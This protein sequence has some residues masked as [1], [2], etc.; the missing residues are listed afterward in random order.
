VRHVRVARDVGCWGHTACA[1]AFKSLTI[2]KNISH[3]LRPL[4]F[5]QRRTRVFVQSLVA[6]LPFIVLSSGDQRHNGTV[7][8][9]RTV[10]SWRLASSSS[11]RNPR[12][13]SASGGSS[14]PAWSPAACSTGGRCSCRS[15]RHTC[16]YRLPPLNTCLSFVLL[17][18]L[19][20]VNGSHKYSYDDDLSRVACMHVCVL[21]EIIFS[22]MQHPRMDDDDERI[23]RRLSNTR[24][25]RVR[26]K[27]NE[28]SSA[29]RI[30]F[31]PGVLKQ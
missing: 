21:Y 18:L 10:S 9:L 14:S 4:V 11:R 7:V 22:Y 17:L 20:R 26:S 15:S 5:F 6:C 28:N 19:A 13:R 30:Y 3:H 25:P 29:A 16:R 1:L 8:V 27:K 31:W 23:L 2:S 24:M 12:C